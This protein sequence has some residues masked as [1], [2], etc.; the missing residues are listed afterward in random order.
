MNNH[1]II[2]VDVETSGLI[3]SEG[4]LLEVAA[5]QLDNYLNILS[6]KHVI[7]DFDLPSN[8]D[9]YVVQMHMDN[10]LLYTEPTGTLEDIENYLKQFQKIIFLGNSVHFDRDWLVYHIPSI[11]PHLHHRLID[12]S[13]FTELYKL[14]HLPEKSTSHR[15][16]D[17]IL[18]SIATAKM[19]LSKLTLV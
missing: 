9:D 1:T 15:A 11:K 10:G 13:S 18:C 5:Y 19:Y 2:A 6:G 17:D 7:L 3:P 8:T 16:V 12:I 4:I 14:P